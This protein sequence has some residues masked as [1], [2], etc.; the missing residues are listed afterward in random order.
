MSPLE[1]ERRGRSW[2]I[3]LT[4]AIVYAV[5]FAAVAVIDAA[6]WLMALLALFTLPALR[7]ALTDTTAGLTIGDAALDW[8]SGARRGQVRLDEIA[9]VRLDT[10]WDLSLRATLV[11]KDGKT[12]RLPQ[13]SLPPS[14]PFETALTA[15]GLP[16]ERHHFAVF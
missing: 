12:V 14:A 6:W 16:V 4:L 9:R 2:P 1:F 10:R 7:D 13:E 11:L 5:L 15:R 3:L 8:H